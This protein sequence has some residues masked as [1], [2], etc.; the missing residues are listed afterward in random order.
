MP[1]PLIAALFSRLLGVELPGFGTCY[2]KQELEFL[3][4]AALD[5][6]LTASVEIIRLRPKKG[7]VDLETLCRDDADRL[8]CRGRALVLTR[9]F[10]SRRPS[11]GI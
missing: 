9:P 1:E 10:Q 11:A 4:P 7:L 6:P 8:I 3:H 2:L 5:R